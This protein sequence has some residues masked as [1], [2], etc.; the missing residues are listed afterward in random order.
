LINRSE[1]SHSVLLPE[2]YSDNPLIN[3]TKNKEIVYLSRHAK[4]FLDGPL[5]QYAFI[6]P[7]T[8]D[9]NRESIYGAR[10]GGFRLMSLPLNKYVK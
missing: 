7:V 2:V 4:D 8:F 10:E 5:N 9:T 3:E 1:S 6:L